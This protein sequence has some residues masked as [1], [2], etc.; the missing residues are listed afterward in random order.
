MLK[1]NDRVNVSMSSYG[2]SANGKI[3]GETPKFWR[4]KITNN[5]TFGKRWKDQKEDICLFHKDSLL[6][7]GFSKGINNGCIT[8]ISRKE[9]KG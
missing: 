4:V 3:I 6:N 8:K 7:R 1:V 9:V 5:R 2:Y